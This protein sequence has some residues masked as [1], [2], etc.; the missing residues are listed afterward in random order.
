MELLASTADSWALFWTSLVTAV[1]L[2]PGVIYAYY[3]LEQWID[4]D[5]SYAGVMASVERRHSQTGK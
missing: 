5:D 3:V 2:V 4:D 1:L